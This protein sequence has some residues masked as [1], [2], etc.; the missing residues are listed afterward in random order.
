MTPSLPKSPSDRS[1]SISG[2]KLKKL[3][4][5]DLGRSSRL[6]TKTPA[7]WGMFHLKFHAKILI[8]MFF[9]ISVH[10]L[11]RSQDQDFVTESV[12]TFHK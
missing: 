2:T 1:I 7:H 10:L 12:I 6:S 5:E 11:H 9:Q 3:S 8:L 4:H